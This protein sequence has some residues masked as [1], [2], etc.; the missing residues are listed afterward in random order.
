MLI[1]AAYMTLR[2]RFNGENSTPS[3]NTQHDR[4]FM[5]GQEH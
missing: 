1:S 3:F 5:E 2:F 4:G